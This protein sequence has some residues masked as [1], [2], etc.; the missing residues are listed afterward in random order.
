MLFF[1]KQKTAYEM[2]ISDWSSDV[3]SSDLLKKAD[4]ARIVNLSSILGSIALHEQPGSPI[5]E[6]K[7]VPAYSASKSAVNAYTAHLAWE[8]RDTPIKVNAAHPG[9]VQTDRNHDGGEI[10]AG[11]GARTNP[12]PAL[13]AAQG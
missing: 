13:P 9:Y 4:A 8:L 2:R 7:I 12:A 1:F 5:H 11:E 6:M 10:E 3:C